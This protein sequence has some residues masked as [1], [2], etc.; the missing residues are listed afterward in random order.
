[1]IL[2]FAF[3]SLAALPT[4]RPFIDP[5]ALPGGTWWLTL[6]PLALLV[7]MVYKAVRV[8]S[9]DRYLPNVLLMAAQI[10]V[11]MAS[12]AVGAHLLVLWIVPA[13]GG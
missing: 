10:V 2:S 4:W 13:L 8:R 3:T 6:I 12:L 1:M 7:S 5:I 11:A 9:M